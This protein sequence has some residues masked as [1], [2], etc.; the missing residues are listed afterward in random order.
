MYPMSLFESGES[1]GEI[2]LLE[3]FDNPNMDID[4][5]MS[6]AGIND[7]IRYACRGGWPASLR[8]RNSSDSYKVAKD[9]LEGVVESDITKVDKVR[10]DPNWQW[11]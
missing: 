10:R 8:L 5:I 2:S 3:L 7:L 11:Q 9:Y 4:G 1:S 6:N